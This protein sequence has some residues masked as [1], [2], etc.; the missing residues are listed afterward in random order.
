ML[1][2]YAEE[3]SEQGKQTLLHYDEDSGSFQYKLPGT[4]AFLA[5]SQIFKLFK[6][7]QRS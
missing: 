3:T 7:L 1:C 4:Q 2:P 5:E 6:L